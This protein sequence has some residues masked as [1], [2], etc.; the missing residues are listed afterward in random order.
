VGLDLGSTGVRAVA[1]VSDGRPISTAREDVAVLRG[2]GGTAEL[3]INTYHRA[4]E[5]CVEHVAAE[6]RRRGDPV[7]AVSF[8]CQGETVVAVD[9]SGRP[10]SDAIVGMDARGGEAVRTLGSRL[11]ESELYAITGQPANPMFSVYKIAALTHRLREA[12]AYRCLTDYLLQSWGLEPVIDW[13]CAARVGAFDVVAKEW[14]QEVLGA[15]GQDYPWLKEARLS[16]PVP[17][18]QP[19]GTP[20]ARTRGRLGLDPGVV[21][22][23]GTHDQSA[24]FIGAGSRPVVSF[25][26]S[27]CVTVGAPERFQAGLDHGLRPA[28]YPVYAGLWVALAGTAAGGWNLEWYASLFAGTANVTDLLAEMAN[29]PAP[30]LMLP[31]L[32][33]ANTL[34]ND[35]L[36]RG[37]VLGLSLDTSRAELT[38]AVIESGGYELRR[39]VDALTAMG[40]TIDDL[41]ATGAAS[42]DRRTLQIR[43]DSAAIT[44][45][46]CGRD[47]AARGAAMLAASATGAEL[48][49]PS[50]Q[51]AVAPRPEWSKWHRDQRR[52]YDDAVPHV[53]ALT[54]ALSRADLPL[55]G[56][57]Q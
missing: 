38:R 12:A 9:E 20:D 21:I 22:A 10:V 15:L 33:G 54:R 28:Q 40:A 11:N 53:R 8:S 27:D 48:P 52:V 24:A 57:H 3:P 7:A 17:C 25:G 55:K 6:S 13:A 26:S 35:P 23:A 4:A 34:A 1:Y 51:D 19:V 49:A 18:G 43:A 41:A 42:E 47:A 37:A 44:L 32:A 2:H 30:L 5:R 31:Y 29:S 56:S 36:A 45:R 16:R 50:D 46:P 39:T 14:S